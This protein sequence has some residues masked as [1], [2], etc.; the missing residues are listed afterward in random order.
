MRSDILYRVLLYYI[1][2]LIHQLFTIYYCIGDFWGKICEDLKAK[3][4]N[5]AFLLIISRLSFVN[6]LYHLRK[7]FLIF[8]IINYLL[9][10]GIHKI[11]KIFV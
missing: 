1:K 9:I 3:I 5:F 4:R 10:L 8:Q 11:Q 2:Q 6:F 7:N